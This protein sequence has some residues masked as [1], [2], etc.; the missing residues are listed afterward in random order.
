MRAF[1]SQINDMKKTLL[2]L[3]AAAPLAVSGQSKISMAGLDLLE[4]HRTALVANSTDVPDQLVPVIITPHSDGLSQVLASMGIEADDLG[5]TVV[6]NVPVSMLET[7]ASLPEVNFLSI[8]QDVKASMDFARPACNV[9]QVQSGFTYNGSNYQFDGT[10]V[11]ASLYDSGMDANHANF[12]NADGTSRVKRLWAF[13]T[14]TT[15]KE[16]TPDSRFSNIS[17][18]TTENSSMTHATHVAGIMGGSYNRESKYAKVSSAAGTSQQLTNGDLP[19]YGVATGADLAFS[20][21]SLNTSYILAGL[22][23]IVDYAD[24]TGMPFVINLSLGSTVG[25]HDGTDAYSQQLAEYGKKGIICI[26]A[27]NDGDVPL[28]ICRQVTSSTPIKTMFTDNKGEGS[29]DVWGQGSDAL[30]VSLVLYNPTTNSTTT[31]ATVTKA[32]ESASVST[33]NSSFAAYYSGS[34]TMRADV[35]RLNNRFNVYCSGSFKPLSTSTAMKLGIVVE[36]S[37]T[38]NVYVYGTT[39]LS[40]TSNGYAGW[41]NGSAE[42]SI[43][44]ACTAANVVSV[45]SFTT[46]RTWGALSNGP[47]QYS[48]SD[49]AVGKISPFSSYGKSFDG[50][51]LPLICAPG[52]GIVSSMSRFYLAQT[53]TANTM[54]ASADFNGVTSYWGNSQGTS[55]ACPFVSGVVALWLQA[56]PTLT[57]DQVM[58]VIDN[59]STYSAISMK[60]GR[61]GAGKIDALKGVQYVLEKYS[62]IGTVWDND[63][64]RLLV[65]PN[66]NG[67]DVTLAGEAEFDVDVYDLQG[68]TV[69]SRKGFN[70]SATVDTDMLSAG[71]YVLNVKSSTFNSS[72]KISVR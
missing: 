48:N 46:R 10:G 33:A 22:K 49:M 13:T 9:D 52:A 53:G 72:R 1:I 27:G 54:T 8:G 61:W 29:I 31:L 45:G 44:D 35:N 14:S 68:R 69:T 4:K 50:T 15:P 51:Q 70:G 38:Q 32:G 56:C 3:L 16:Y 21:G 12:L 28:S 66:G 55:M 43:N 19:F 17:S 7:V 30:T 18:F 34:L 20:V 5:A 40:F 57:Y 65:T 42:N 47:Y 2:F 60:G 26:A 64:A 39:S 58:D 6:A 59:T 63:E 25:P 67:Y 23:K 24:Q 36:S 37:K 11:I 62:S 41:D 71:I